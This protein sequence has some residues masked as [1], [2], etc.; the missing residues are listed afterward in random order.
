MDI[1][2]QVAK[3]ERFR[4]LHRGS[5]ILVLPNVWD[6]AGARLVEQTGLPAVATSSAGIA[7]SLGYPDGQR[8]PC[9][10]MVEALRRIA[11]AVDVPVTADFESGYGETP[12]AVSENVR[13]VLE[14]G[15]VG[16]NFEDSGDHTA[17]DLCAVDLQVE[18]I[19]ALREMAATV[20]IP[21]VI[22]ARTDVYLLGIGDPASRF[23]HA[24]R[25]ANAY[26]KAGADCLFV[27]GVMDAETIGRLTKA[28]DGPVNILAGPGCPS[29]PELKRLGV[30]RVSVGSRP[31]C[32]AMGL[33]RRIMEELRDSGTYDSLKEPVV[34]YAFLNKLVG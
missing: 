27:P 26:R 1:R 24:V 34:N 30:A 15:A 9:P 17:T 10:E 21:L 7:F 13:S 6:V 29:V 5:Q 2:T 14:A 12:A 31:M 33:M 23:D 19:K 22:N 4:A 11:R 8:I 18:K 20:G 32:A 25:R 16:I 28:I 3:A